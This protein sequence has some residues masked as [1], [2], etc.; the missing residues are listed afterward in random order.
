MVLDRVLPSS[1]RR[2][3]GLKLVIALLVVMVS[4]AAIA[5]AY[6]YKT[7]QSMEVDVEHELKAVS[8]LRANEIDTWLESLRMETRASSTHPMFESDD[9]ERIRSHLNDLVAND[10]VP[11]S[12]VAVHYLDT[13]SMTFVTISSE[14]MIGVSPKEKGV[15]FATNTQEFDDPNDAYVTDPFQV[16]VVDFPV[17]AVICPVPEKTDRAVVHMVDISR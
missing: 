8:E 10:M 1:I 7:S 2:R 4:A 17:M 6:T 11:D 3:Y 15:P 5:R 12:V 9:T 13:R 14:E 16:D